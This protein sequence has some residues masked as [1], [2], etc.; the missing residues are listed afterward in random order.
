MATPIETMPQK[1][2]APKRK[3]EAEIAKVTDVLLEIHQNGETSRSRII[4]M[5]GYAG[6]R[7]IHKFWRF[8]SS[9]YRSEHGITDK[10]YALADDDGLPDFIRAALT[11]SDRS[12]VLEAVRRYLAERERTAN[13]FWEQ[14]P[15]LRMPKRVPIRFS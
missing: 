2:A 8:F 6:R 12:K 11:D 3:R 1:N 14:H 4:D 7:A 15:Y 10:Y 13:L 9:R 5:F